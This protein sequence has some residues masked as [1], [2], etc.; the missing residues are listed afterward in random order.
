MQL[1]G[2]YL[3]RVGAS[4]A[5]ATSVSDFQLK[6]G[7]G[8]PG[9]RCAEEAFRLR[10]VVLDGEHPS[11]VLLSPGVASMDHW[12][13]EQPWPT[14]TK[15]RAATFARAALAMTSCFLLFAGM[16]LIAKPTL[17]EHPDGLPVRLVRVICRS[18]S[19]LGCR[20]HRRGNVA[21]R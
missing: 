17:T 8:R 6:R 7:L 14:A 15:R 12:S 21:N 1:R 5:R 10:I 11:C 13:L 3:R 16:L 20:F 18:A 9:P 4:A 19:K 2:R